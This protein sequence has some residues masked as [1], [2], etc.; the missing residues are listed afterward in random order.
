MAITTVVLAKL[1]FKKLILCLLSGSIGVVCRPPSVESETSYR[2]SRHSSPMDSL[3]RIPLR[4]HR[5]LVMCYHPTGHLGLGKQVSVNAV[6]PLKVIVV[7][8][9]RVHLD[10]DA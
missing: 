4:M 3:P 8:A 2:C 5:R 10:S 6:Y 9:M 7:T 1:R